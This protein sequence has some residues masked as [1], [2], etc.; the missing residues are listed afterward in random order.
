MSQRQ[1][2]HDSQRW[3]VKVGSAL[4]TDNGQGLDLAMLDA[5]AAEIC[6]I[7]NKGID[8]V[9]VSSGAVAAGMEQLHWQNRPTALSNLQ[10]A[11]AVG[12][13]RLIR[14]WEQ[15]FQRFGAQSAQ[16]L[17]THA[18]HSNRQRYL[19]ARA[20]LNALLEHGIAPVVN[21]NDTV[22]TDEIRF[23]DNDTLGALVTNLIDADAL[24]LLTDQD[25]LFTADPRKVPGATLIKEARAHDKALDAMAGD[26]S[27]QLG[28]GGMQTK[29]RAGRLAASSG[30]VT[31]IAHGKTPNILSRLYQQEETG[32]LLLPDQEKITARKQ[33]LQGHLR[34]LGVLVLDNGAV[35]VLTDKGSSLLPVGVVSVEGTFQRGEMVTCRD[36]SG[37]EVARGMVN[38]SDGEARKIIGKPSSAICASLGYEGEEELIHRDNMVLAEDY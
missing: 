22:I 38:Y 33:W 36:L 14:A 20:T 30:A 11:A 24:I 26:G 29:L 12:Q 19:N 21:E 27:G 5:L 8:V 6:A 3:V 17:L 25:G 32:T 18:D 15:V 4:I 37:K 2:L 10:A 23:G 34:T 16:V 13:A 31:V 9:V 28:R 35:H 1:R 7:R